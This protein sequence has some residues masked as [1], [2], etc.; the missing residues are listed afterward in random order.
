M[1]EG[2]ALN[3]MNQAYEEIETKIGDILKRTPEN[4]PE[5]ADPMNYKAP[6]CDETEWNEIPGTAAEFILHLQ[7]H[8]QTVVTYLHN[9][10]KL[11]SVGELRGGLETRM[12]IVDK[13]SEANKT[14]LTE[15]CNF[16]QKLH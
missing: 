13:V 5:Y 4:Y 8:H 3:N 2:I 14:Q 16:I 1:T 7:H 12:D 10:N 9:Q 6:E 11:E 15:R